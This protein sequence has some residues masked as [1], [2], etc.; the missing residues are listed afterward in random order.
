MVGGNLNALIPSRIVRRSLIVVVSI[1]ATLSLATAVYAEDFSAEI[2]ALK[3]Q[4]TAEQTQAAQMQGVASDYQSKV[5]RLQSQINALQTQISLNQVEYDQISAA[6]ADNQTKLD[7]A[8]AALGA[9]LK[10]MYLGS[11]ETPLEMLISSKSLSDYFNQQQYQ[12]SVKNKIQ[13]TMTTILTL[14]QQLSDQQKQIGGILAS[15][16][17]QKQQIASQKAQVSQLLALAQQN[18]AAANQQVKAT[19]S[20][21]SQ[22]QAEQAALLEAASHSYTGSIPGASSGSGGACANQSTGDNG[23]YPS[24]WCNAAQD[25]IQT[26]S[27][28][29]RECVSWAGYRW[30]Q[31]G[32]SYVNWGNANTWDDYARS[33]GYS[34]NNTP[35]VGAVA[36][37]DAGPFGHV[38]VVEAV[39]G[40]SVVVSEM[41]YDDAGH[42]RYGVYS[43]SYFKYIHP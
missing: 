16:S 42:F 14:Q 17:D 25:S 1:V 29:N 28:L 32:G 37:T 34:V 38:A 6:I 39:Q 8:K 33:A 19:N 22:K 27:G 10:S 11:G 31:M 36:Q 35:S 20:Q 18:V 40:S 26:P 30:H 3:D 15:L 9:D 5:N 2:A 7:A 41:N 12:D 23:G 43:S 13:S 4:A 24:V 21:L